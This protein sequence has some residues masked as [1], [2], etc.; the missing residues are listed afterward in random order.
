LFN[1][2]AS[3]ATHAAL[4]LLFGL[5]VSGVLFARLMSMLQLS[6]YPAR[7]GA[8]VALGLAGF[9]TPGPFAG[10]FFG[11]LVEMLGWGP[12]AIFTVVLPAVIAALLM[13]FFD[14]RSMRSA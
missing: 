7:I 8:A 1:L 12:A 11:K 14:M 6:A 13:G 3:P 2:A 9:Y 10:Y 4:S 5:L